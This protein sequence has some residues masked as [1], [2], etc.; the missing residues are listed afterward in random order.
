MTE[1]S[2]LKKISI[3]LFLILAAYPVL[4]RA[5]SGPTEADPQFENLDPEIKSAPADPTL[6]VVES[7]DPL[8]D[9]LPLKNGRSIRIGPPAQTDSDV[10]QYNS[11]SQEQK[12]RFQRIRLWLLSK[13]AQTLAISHSRLGA[14]VVFKNKILYQLGIKKKN[15]NEEAAPS[16]EDIERGQR[17]AALILNTLNNNLWSSA[18]A[19][20]N[21]D[22]QGIM[23]GLS[24]GYSF[25]GKKSKSGKLVSDSDPMVMNIGYDYNLKQ[26]I[27]SFW[28]P[29]HKMVFGANFDGGLSIKIGGYRK[30]KNYQ[31]IKQSISTINH[32]PAAPPFCG[33]SVEYNP[34]GD[35]WATAWNFTFPGISEL[36][37]FLHQ[38]Y[39]SNY[40]PLVSYSV[41]AP[42]EMLSHLMNKWRSFV[43]SFG[44]NPEAQIPT[45]APTAEE[46][47]PQKPSGASLCA[48]LLKRW[49]VN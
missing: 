36:T 1:M 17:S 46:S 44:P 11:L 23:I 41:T 29:K 27:I 10:K 5:Q 8:I 21:P 34:S 20:T 14:F 16:T 26:Y 22:E 6:K 12:E 40:T 49:A 30:N 39:Y 25:G 32:N 7:S 43:S 15:N 3:A 24:P 38:T 2:S 4:V 33:L 35:Y 42:S 28:R 45:K 31:C 47:Q 18:K 37:C 19:M 48:K 9:I 13:T